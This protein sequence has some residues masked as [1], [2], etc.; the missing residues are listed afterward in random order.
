MQENIYMSQVESNQAKVSLIQKINE[1]VEIEFPLEETLKQLPIVFT[2]SKNKA[3]LISFSSLVVGG[4]MLWFYLSFSDA[5]WIFAAVAG[6]LMVLG[7]AVG[8]LASCF[9]PPTLIIDQKGVHNTF[10]NRQKT[11]FIWADVE[12][13][14]VMQMGTT[15]AVQYQFNKASGKTRMPGGYMLFNTGYDADLTA[16]TLEILRQYFTNENN[17]KSEFESIGEN[18]IIAT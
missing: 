15:R 13:I 14:D 1:P 12:S 2:Q 16:L 11:V 4:L 18:E 17:L 3:L 5:D 7:A 9:P 10:R 8:L 6:F